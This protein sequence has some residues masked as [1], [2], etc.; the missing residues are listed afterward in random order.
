MFSLVIWA[1]SFY[2]PLP[3]EQDHMA[4][5]SL[6]S[7]R[8]RVLLWLAMCHLTLRAAVPALKCLTALK[9][10]NPSSRDPVL[11]RLELQALLANDQLQ[12]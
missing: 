10:A 9:H 2:F 7:L 1:V 12:V 8:K 4:S 6:A 5:E 11:L 3:Q